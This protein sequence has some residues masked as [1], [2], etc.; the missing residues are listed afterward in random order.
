MSAPA[1]PLSAVQIAALM[2]PLGDAPE[3][4]GKLVGLGQRSVDARYL[5]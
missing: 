2:T 3:P 4:D 1:V 5:A